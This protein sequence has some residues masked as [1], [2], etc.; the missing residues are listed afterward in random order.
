MLI[1]DVLS[2]REGVFKKSSQT[3]LTLFPFSESSETYLTL[4]YSCVSKFHDQVVVEVQVFD[5]PCQLVRCKRSVTVR[6]RRWRKSHECLRQHARVG[7]GPGLSLQV[8]CG[9]GVRG[10]FSLT[11]PPSRL[12]RPDTI[13]QRSAFPVSL[14]KLVPFGFVFLVY[15][16]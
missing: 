13:S 10:D 9:V 1:N 6:R 8:T 14:S 3:R 5:V 4:H 11:A 15:K 2:Q 7:D 16:E 12:D